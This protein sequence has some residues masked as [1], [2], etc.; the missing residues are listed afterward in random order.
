MVRVDAGVDDGDR[1]VASSEAV[2]VMRLLEA[3]ESRRLVVGR[4]LRGPTCRSSS[5]DLVEQRRGRLAAIAVAALCP[6]GAVIF[7]ADN[8]QDATEQSEDD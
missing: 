6:H 5:P 2:A 8:A 1:Y 4:S 3:D 7:D